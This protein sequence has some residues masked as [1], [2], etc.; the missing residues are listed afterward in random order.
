M[1]N[2]TTRRGK[3]SK[4]YRQVLRRERVITDKL[5]MKKRTTSNTK[6]KKRA[7]LIAGIKRGKKCRVGGEALLRVFFGG[8][9]F[10]GT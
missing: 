10:R 8:C 5:W 4:M 1:E 6:R 2:G 3:K 9:W 7:G